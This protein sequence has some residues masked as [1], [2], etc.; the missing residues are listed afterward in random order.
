MSFSKKQVK[1]I[2]ERSSDA[3]KGFKQSISELIEINKD[4]NIEIS[5]C[6]SQIVNAKNQIEENKA[7][8]SKNVSIIEN[9]EKLV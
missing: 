1:T 2:Q 6:E 7:L 8:I 3:T 5:I 4:A 9:L